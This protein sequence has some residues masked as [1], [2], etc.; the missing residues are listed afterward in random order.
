MEEEMIDHGRG[1]DEA[2]GKMVPTGP[3]KPVER[4]PQ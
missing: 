4:K 3:A 1:D 2:W